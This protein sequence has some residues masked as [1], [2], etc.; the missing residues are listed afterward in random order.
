MPRNKEYDRNT[1]VAA[2]THVFHRSGYKGASTDALV[3]A[4]GVNRNS[5]YS[6]FGNKE[7]LFAAA[8]GHYDRE[9]VTRLFGPLESP[10]ATLDQ[11]EALML[12]FASTANSSSGM[13]CLMCNTAAELGGHDDGLQPWI[14]DYFE[15]VHRAFQNA[16]KGAVREGQVAH[17][18]N[19]D[20]EARLLNASCLGIFLMVRSGI[21]T[22]AAQDAIQG[23]LNHLKLLRYEALLERDNPSTK[24]KRRME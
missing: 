15:R 11:I 22:Q 1:L 20:T 2:A 7:G 6:E 14:Q 4:L 12:H 17:S 3:R 18:I 5:V 23:A 21:T 10:S 13:G 24:H 8:L 19:I 9:V 16:L